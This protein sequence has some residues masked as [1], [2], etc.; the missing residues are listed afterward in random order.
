MPLRYP[1]YKKSL[2]LLAAAFVTII[3]RGQTTTQNY[4]RT[5]VPNKAIA[6]NTKLDALTANRDSVQSTIQY[7]DGLGRPLQTV[8]QR[9][10]PG[11]RDIIQPFFYDG[12]GRESRK[13]LPYVDL[14]VSYGSYRATALSSG[15]GVSGYYN[16]GGGTVDGKQTNAVVRTPYPFAQT[17]FEASPLNRVV[18]QGAPGASWRLPGTGDA[19]SS[20]HT[21]RSTTTTNDQST[22]STTNVTANN[23]SRSVALYTAVIHADGSR[24]LARTGNSA[25]YVSGQLYVTIT[26][27]ENWQPS[28]GCFGSTEEYKDKEGHVVL[29]RTYT[30]YKNSSNAD[31]AMMVSTY[32]VYDDLGNLCFVL[33]RGTVPDATLAISQG[34]LDTK[35]YQ[36]RYDGRNRLLGKKIPG[37]GW[38]YMIY[39]ALDQVV[40]TQDSVQRMKAPQEWTVTKYDALGRVVLTGVYQH[41]G[42]TAGADNHVAVQALADVP[43]ALWES[44][45]NTGTG[46]TANSWPQSWATTLN[47]TYYD[48]YTDIPGLPAI[49][50]LHTDTAYSSRTRGL[51]TATKTLVLNTAG[52]Y[53]WSVPYY[54]QEGK[55]LRMLSQHYLGGTTLLSPYNYDDVTTAYNFLKQPVKVTRSHYVTNAGKTAGVLFLTATDSYTYDHVGRKLNSYQQLKHGSNTAQAK[56]LVSQSAYNEIGQ[57]MTKKLHSVNNGTSFLQ[58]LNYRYNARGWLTNINNA[59]LA[60]DPLT[61]NDSNDQFGMELSYDGTATVRPQYNGNIATVKTK[62]ADVNGVAYDALTYDYGYD[63]INRLTDAVSTGTAAKDDYYGEHLRY[64]NMGDITGLG[65]Y[66]KVNGVRVQIDTLTYTYS[67]SYRPGQIDD[68]SAYTGL[69]GFT[70][71]VKSGGEYTYDGNGNQKR[72]QNRGISSIAYNM[73]DLPQTVTRTDGSTVAYIYDAT[74]KKLRK[75]FTGGSTTTV[76]EYVNGIEYDNG[77]SGVTFIQTEEGRARKTGSTYVYEYDLKDH[78]GNTRVTMT[79]DPL[80]ATQLTPKILQRND[81]YAFGYTIQSLQ[82]NIPSPKN[83]Y[84]Y[85]GK[86]LQEETGYYDYGARF[87]DP[88]IGR[89]TSV[90]PL[91]EKGRRWSPYNYGDDN[92]IRNID[93]DGMATQGCCGG[94]QIDINSKTTTS[95]TMFSKKQQELHFGG[96]REAGEVISFT[97]TVATVAGYGASILSGGSSTVLI[98]TGEALEGIG[99]VMTMA[100]DLKEHKYGDVAITMGTNLVF[101]AAGSKIEKLTE[102]GKVGKLGGQILSATNYAYSKVT[103]KAIDAFKVDHA[104]KKPIPVAPKLADT[105]HNQE[106]ERKAQEFF[107]K[108]KSN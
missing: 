95:S 9:A 89:W 101:N 62:T 22:F 83:E 7:I 104:E 108:K 68:A 44:P 17:G 13:Y 21:L 1:A 28:D 57:L 71:R 65:R 103:D 97:G 66:D 12:Y 38:E 99:T 77:P 6:T 11:T 74:G 91:A 37:K 46:Y 34:V 20:N 19:G 60:V 15:V 42:S 82:G 106:S 39:N 72:D 90:D 96:M 16:P 76:T 87:Y 59:A 86:E 30:K 51:V 24:S 54:D 67:N 41:A 63:D 43:G 69:S 100:A 84:L 35:A 64:G 3:A 31:A 40:A 79:W 36:Y 26:R 98:P 105:K 49:Y 94:F 5:R 58:G 27:D 2:L 48:D 78:L 10:S 23:G 25:N 107:N 33:P 50:D 61:S 92:P 8:Q 80:D 88:V 56:V 14:S 55:V 75:L 52:D 18:E 29:K 85:N 70:D 73:L 102:A 81:Y 45:V 32:Y 93:P 4:V 53:L 47:V